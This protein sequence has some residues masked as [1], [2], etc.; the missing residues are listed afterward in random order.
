[1]QL[2]FKLF[3]PL[4]A[5]FLIMGMS[6]AAYAQITCS[7]ASAPVGRATL[8]GHTE[9]VGDLTF[10]CEAQS[11]FTPSG[12]TMTVDFGGVLITN[13]DDTNEDGNID[14]I[15]DDDITVDADDASSLW[16]DVGVPTFASVNNESGIVVI[17]LG[18]GATTNRSNW[19][20][21]A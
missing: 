19:C 4:M 11:G 7:V 5:L 14:D 13:D 9:P 2:R 16:T 6:N 1:M 20:V 10:T 18:S 21:H 15:D 8:S 3:V 12:G 17:T